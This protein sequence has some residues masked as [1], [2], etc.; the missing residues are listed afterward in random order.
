[1]LKYITAAIFLAVVVA[2]PNPEANTLPVTTDTTILNGSGVPSIDTY[3][4]TI[5]AGQVTPSGVPLI[6]S[7]D[8]LQK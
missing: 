7:P 3:K 1:M 4:Q 8:D 5:P 6:V 2:T